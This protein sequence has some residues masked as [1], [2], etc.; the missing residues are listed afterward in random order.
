[1]RPFIIVLL[2]MICSTNGFFSGAA[3]AARGYYLQGSIGGS[4]QKAIGSIHPDLNF[5]RV[6]SGELGMFVTDNAALG[7]RL[8]IQDNDLSTA[9]VDWAGFKVN[10]AEFNTN[11]YEAVARASVWIPR[12]SGLLLGVGAGLSHFTSDTGIS[13]PKRSASAPMFELFSGLQFTFPNELMAN[14]RVGYAYRDL[15]MVEAWYGETN[16]D[17]LDLDLSGWFFEIGIG[18]HTRRGWSPPK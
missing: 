12:Q 17:P 7:L 3:Q 5:A 18:G 8:S 6:Y 1:M 4:D 10:R 15:G 11:V 9:R 13:S 2:S 14:C 16:S